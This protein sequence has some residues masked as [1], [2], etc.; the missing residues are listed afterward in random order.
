MAR[1]WR[2]SRKAPDWNAY[3]PK[4]RVTREPMP[5]VK[6]MGAIVDHLTNSWKVKFDDEDGVFFLSKQH[7]TYVEVPGGIEFTIPAWLWTKMA[8]EGGR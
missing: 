2:Y 1:G 4:L 3:G 7:A 6:K 8:E 5:D